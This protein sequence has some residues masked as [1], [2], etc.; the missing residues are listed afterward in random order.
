M[1]LFNSHKV[2][3]PCKQGSLTIYLNMTPVVNL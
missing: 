2:V 3:R 1:V